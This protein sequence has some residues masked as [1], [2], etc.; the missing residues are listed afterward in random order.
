MAVSPEQ[1]ALLLQFSHNSKQYTLSF[2][3]HLTVCIYFQGIPHI[4][5]SS[6]FAVGL[7]CPCALYSKCNQSGCKRLC[8][9]SEQT[10]SELASKLY[11]KYVTCRVKCANNEM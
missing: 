1:Y 4:I 9:G 5:H 8:L 6:D 11:R 10:D 3:D 7:Q 2:Y